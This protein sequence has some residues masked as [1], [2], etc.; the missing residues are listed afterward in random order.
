M[1]AETTPPQ[2]SRRYTARKATAAMGSQTARMRSGMITDRAGE[3]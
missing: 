2:P 3:R 1:R